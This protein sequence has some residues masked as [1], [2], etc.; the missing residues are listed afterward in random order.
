M[1][2]KSV[3]LYPQPEDRDEFNK[4]YKEEHIPLCEEHLGRM[5]KFVETKVL[6]APAGKPPYYKIVEL[7]YDSMDDLQADFGSEGG[8]A[9]AKN[10]FAIS[11]GGKPVIMVCSA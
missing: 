5:T 8:T 7:H 3:V 11:S 1:G 9:V 2:V 6:G 4:R 10:A